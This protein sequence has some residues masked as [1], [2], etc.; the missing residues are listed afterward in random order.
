MPSTSKVP[1]HFF[2]TR[3]RPSTNIT[4]NLVTRTVA[5][6]KLN[7]ANHQ[8]YGHRLHLVWPV[9]IGVVNEAA[10]EKVFIWSPDLDEF[11]IELQQSFQEG[12]CGCVFDP[13][14]PLP[15]G[16]PLCDKLKPDEECEHTRSLVR[17][18]HQA[19]KWPKCTCPISSTT[20]VFSD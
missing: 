20:V 13:N 12:V 15:R 8:H 10:L 5:G 18:D 11:C 7:I 19:G 14:T 17:D 4:S 3:R 1:R 16:M 9:G 6:H 2:H